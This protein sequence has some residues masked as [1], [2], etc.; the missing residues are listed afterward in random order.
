MNF[1]TLITEDEGAKDAGK[2]LIC[3]TKGIE[4]N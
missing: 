3:V 2:E 1:Q 4:D